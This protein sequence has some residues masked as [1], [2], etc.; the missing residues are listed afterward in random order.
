MKI[1]FYESINS[2]DFLF[3]MAIVPIGGFLTY[4]FFEIIK[5]LNL[6]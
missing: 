1:D 2:S 4:V 5:L 3:A 6:I